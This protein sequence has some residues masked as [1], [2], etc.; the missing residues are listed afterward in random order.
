MPAMGVR[1]YLVHKNAPYLAQYKMLEYHSAL[2]DFYN[3]HKEFVH[4]SKTMLLNQVAT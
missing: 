3:P 4:A 1:A 2:I